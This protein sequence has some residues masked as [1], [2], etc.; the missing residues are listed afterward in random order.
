[1]FCALAL[2]ANAS[3]DV[4][5]AAAVCALAALLAGGS[6]LPP[7]NTRG[8]LTP[9]GVAL[10][11][12]AA[13]MIITNLWA[14]P[15]YTNAASYHAAF[16]LGGYWL[17]QRAG[18]ENAALLL[19]VALAF[20]VGLAAWSIGQRAIGTAARGHALFETPATL[21]ATI[22][23][24]L[25]PALVLLVAGSRNAWLLAGTAIA[26]SGLIVSGSRGG[27]LALFAAAAAACILFQRAKIRLNRKLALV[28]GAAF[29]VGGLLLLSFGSASAAA[30]L[31][32]Y[33]AAIAAL[34]ESSAIFGSGYFSFRHVVDAAQPEIPGF[35][36]S[37]TDFV[38]NDYLQVLLEL[39]IPGLVF[40]LLIAA[41]PTAYA[42][43]TLPRLEAPARVAVVAIAAAT[44]SMALH[45]LVDFPFYSPICLLIYGACCGLLSA[46]AAG[47]KARGRAP[48]PAMVLM[49][50]M[51]IWVLAKPAIAEAA[52]RYAA[53]QWDAGRGADAAWWFEAARQAEPG[54]WRYHW[55]AGQFWY[56]QARANANAAAA[57]MA[58][59]AF[60]EG[61]AAN[62]R[63]VRSLLGRI[64]THLELRALLAS[65][66]DPATLRSWAELAFALA[67]RDAEVNA[68][69]ALIRDISHDSRSGSDAKMRSQP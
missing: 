3:V 15:A 39:G 56:L 31:D 33:R 52:A 24:V 62:P 53:H 67:P 64:S 50:A 49:A 69:R 44:I 14:S 36:G 2:A 51:A 11:G 59:E 47:G 20:A 66:A 19:G 42:W 60:A 63:E 5:A 8:E 55:S 10:F 57:R 54:D 13:W 25:L 4:S 58:D 46:W 23:L 22:N 35:A 9:L 28:I 48:A 7:R 45:A 29:A 26:A 68:R 40:L 38:H 30:R 32:L 65:P 12:F 37:R 1:L 6:L 41:L 27:W 17:G 61:F 43:R 16:L 34:R 21:A 18:R